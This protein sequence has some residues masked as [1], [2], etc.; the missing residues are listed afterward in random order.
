M[1]KPPVQFVHHESAES[2]AGLS[3]MNEGEADVIMQLVQDSLDEG[4]ALSDIGIIS[5]YAAQT[6]LLRKRAAAT[7]GEDAQD[8]EIA[9]VDGFQGREKVTIILSTVRS[10][11]TGS[12]GFLSDARR[13]NVALTRA[14][15]QLY[16]VGNAHT[17]SRINIWDH[18]AHI[19]ADY[20]QWAMKVRGLC[21]RQPF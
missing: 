11:K 7:F 16:V 13:L 12:I 15:D 1:P 21:S 2:K 5:A 18:K 17:L 4:R 6:I 9:T 10:N 3:I 14:R 19:F 20:V 8:L